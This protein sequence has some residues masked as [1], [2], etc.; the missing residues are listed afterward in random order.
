MGEYVRNSQDI[1]H[2]E[3]QRIHQQWLQMMGLELK[4]SKSGIQWGKKQVLTA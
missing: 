2:K 3:V 1:N 4:P